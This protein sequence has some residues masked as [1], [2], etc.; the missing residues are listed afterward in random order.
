M[1][2]KFPSLQRKDRRSPD[3]LLLVDLIVVESPRKV[4]DVA[5]YAK[6]AGLDAEVAATG[7]HLVDLP[8]MQEGACIDLQSFGPTKVVPRSTDAAARITR[9]RSSIS[10]AA[11]VIIA[12][13]PD[14]EGEAIAAQVLAYTTSGRAW[15]AHFHEITATGIARGLAE[16]HPHLDQ[17]SLEAALARRAV[18]RLAGWHGTSLVFQKLPDLKGVSAGRLQ[19]AALRL[20]VDREDEHRKF[21]PVTTF[22]LRLKVQRGGGGEGFWATLL[23]GKAPHRFSTKAEAELASVPSTVRVRMVFTKRKTEQAPPPFEAT[24][25]LQVA[26][27]AL[28]LSVKDAT[29]ATQQLFELGLT[30][31]PRTDS[32]R[33]ADEAVAWAR[34]ELMQRFGAAYVPSEPRQHRDRG[35]AGQ[36]AHEAL[37]PTLCTGSPEAARARAGQWGGAYGLIE[38]RFL[39]SQAAARLTDS[40]AVLL[41][42]EGSWLARGETEVFG[43]W[44]DVLGTSATEEGEVA[45]LDEEDQGILGKLPTLIEGEVLAVVSVE[46]TTH[47]TRPRPLLTQ[48]SLVAELKRLG[49]GRPSTYQSAVSLL[50]GR[51]WVLERR[52][53]EKGCKRRLPCL[54]STE[55]GS[56]LVGLLK[57]AVP[58]LVNY[59]FTA[60]LESGLDDIAQGKRTRREVGAAWWKQFREELA[61]GT[62]LAPKPSRPDLGGCPRCEGALRAGRLRLVRGLAK[63]GRAYEFAACDLDQKDAVVCGYTTAIHEGR[64]V[65]RP[66]CP[67]CQLELKPVTKRNG[68]HS[69]VCDQHGWFLADARWQLVQAPSCPSCGKQMTHRERAQMKGSFFWACFE[70]GVF[71]DSDAFGS[72]QGPVRRK[73]QATGAADLK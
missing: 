37:R 34:N 41:E 25:W 2:R 54:V 33:V 4:K 48:A 57:E 22:G 24:S 69:G 70:D 13:D 21:S 43:G 44:R 60:Q 67:E 51:G 32:V 30:T 73:N 27:K 61:R 7:G 39:A 18:D 9:L 36:G 62:K 35:S 49:I 16:M 40:T 20:V 5:H 47:V 19:S 26:Q 59:E 28:G 65:R 38:T 55:I 12:T 1:R 46:V 53:Q 29:A 68:G 58:S 31:Y 42:G 14:R 17:G 3:R 11:R 63:A 8:P 15:R 23:E 45:P 50:L 71:C 64:P 72:A 52:R 56:A 10:R 6:L 66:S